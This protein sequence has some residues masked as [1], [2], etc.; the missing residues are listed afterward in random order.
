MRLGVKIDLHCRL[1]HSIIF[2]LK[3]KHLAGFHLRICISY[4]R[5]YLLIG[6]RHE[7]NTFLINHQSKHIQLFLVE[8]VSLADLEH[9][10]HL[11]NVKVE[12]LGLL[13]MVV[14]FR[15]H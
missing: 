9:A 1:T 8:V 2:S 3:L 6:A 15:S 10:L 13:L 11:N 5:L 12:V 4:A 7:W 14:E